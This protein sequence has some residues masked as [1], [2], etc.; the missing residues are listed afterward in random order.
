[1]QTVT[2]LTTGSTFCGGPVVLGRSTTVDRLRVVCD[3]PVQCYVLPVE[4][5]LTHAT[6]AM[7]KCVKW[8]AI[9][10]KTST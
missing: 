7:L 5:F 3:E 8:A 10:Q 2:R 9:L 1:M 6:P 4:A